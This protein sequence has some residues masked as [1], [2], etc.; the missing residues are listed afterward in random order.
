MHSFCQCVCT[1]EW[2]S[3]MLLL[4]SSIFCDFFVI[5]MHLLLFWSEVYSKRKKRLPTRCVMSWTSCEAKM[6][7]HLF[8]CFI[9]SICWISDL[10]LRHLMFLHRDW[11]FWLSNSIT[12]KKMKKKTKELRVIIQKQKVVISTIALLLVN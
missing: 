7:Y 5:Q 3:C 6:H 9:A 10:S 2:P 1:L 11:Q 4:G 8:N 12:R